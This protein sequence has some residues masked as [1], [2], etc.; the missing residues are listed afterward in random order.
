MSSIWSSSFFASLALLFPLSSPLLLP[1]PVPLPLPLSLSLSLPLPLPL[2]LPLSLPLPDLSLFFST[3]FS[4]SVPLAST[5]LFSSSFWSSSASQS[6]SSV[7]E[8]P[9]FSLG[10]T[11][12]STDETSGS[13]FSSFA[14]SLLSLDAGLLSSGAGLLSRGGLSSPAGFSSPSLLRG[15]RGIFSLPLSAP[16]F[17]FPPKGPRPPRGLPSGFNGASS[18]IVLVLARS[19]Q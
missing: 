4:G 17:G 7:F 8:T 12:F 15:L 2:P 14:R 6:L 9:T 5:L 18:D 13:C 19:T 3:G 10:E 16:S 1:L 11:F